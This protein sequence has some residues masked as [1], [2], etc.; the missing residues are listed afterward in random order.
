M[1]TGDLFENAKGT[2]VE[3]DPNE[4]RI[5]LASHRLAVEF[6]EDE[7]LP[8]RYRKSA[9]AA[10][11]K[12]KVK[13]DSEVEKRF[14]VNVQ[15][16]RSLIETMFAKLKP[17]QAWRFINLVPDVQFYRKRKRTMRTLNLMAI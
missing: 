10:Q 2:Q 13:E 6:T 4:D 17:E 3:R 15:C 1:T 14:R 16:W 9:D 12:R 8:A 5:S 11:K 7:L